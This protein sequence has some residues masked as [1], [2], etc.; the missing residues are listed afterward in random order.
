MK[1]LFVIPCCSAK[2]AGG[3]NPPWAGI[4]R[5]PGANR[6]TFLDDHRLRLID[7]YSGLSEEN[8]ARYYRHRGSSKKVARAWR[9]N[10]GIRQSGTMEATIRYRGNLYKAIDKEVLKRLRAGVI[11]NVLIV[12]ALMGIITPNDQIPDYELMMM[13][14]SP[15]ATAVWEFWTKVFATSDSS[16]SLVS[17]FSQFSPV[18]CLMSTTTGY[19]RAVTDILSDRCAYSIVPEEPGQTNKSASWGRVLSDALL[20]G[21]GT[22]Q[23][24][25]ATAESH[26]CSVVELGSQLASVGRPEPLHA[27]ATFDRRTHP[28]KKW[29]GPLC[30]DSEK[31][32]LKVVRPPFLSFISLVA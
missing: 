5:D 9:K 17:V 28:K 15:T 16:Q 13:D 27:L 21:R 29:G 23:E 8:A 19:V 24:I 4:R 3:P 26:H 11:D 30:Q 2:E 14:L 12:S 22:L 10:L 32:F 31:G 25:K 18:Y 20:D 1:P 6:F 7:F